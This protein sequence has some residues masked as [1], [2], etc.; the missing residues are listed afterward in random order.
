MDSVKKKIF[1]VRHGTTAYNETGLLQ[2]RIDNP[3]S[4]SGREEVSLLAEKLKS[5]PIGVIFSSPLKRAIETAELINEFHR[6]PVRIIDQFVEIDMGEWDGVSFAAIQERDID[7]FRRWAADPKIPVPGGESFTQVCRRVKPGI[8]K[9]LA[10]SEENVL[11]TAHATVNRAIL[12]NLLQMSPSVARRFRVQNAAL[13]KLLMHENSGISR[14]V[15]DAWNDT[16]HL[17]VRV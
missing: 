3:L 6:V 12:G 17:G 1:L 8:R 14:I 2:G 4:P 9:V 10:S 15:V 11:I 13:S 16:S 5:E 7:F